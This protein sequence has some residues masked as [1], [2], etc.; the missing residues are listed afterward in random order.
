MTKRES[1]VDT[2]D[3]RTVLG[4]LTAAGLGLGLLGLGIPARAGG[5]G[6]A[7]KA[8]MTEK[9]FRMGVIGPATLSR[10]VSQLAVERATQANAREFARFELREAIA[11]TTVLKELKTPVPPMDAKARATL[12]K[13]ETA[14][15]GLDFDRAYVT[16]QYENHVFL[17]DLATTYL[18]NTTP[19]EPTFPE[20]QGRHLATLALNQFT[21]HVELTARILRE[22]GS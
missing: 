10:M 20:Q 14:A 17:R 21:E 4:R 2:T 3:R 5:A 6:M 7:M 1:A 15:P 11:V 13:I 12:T 19:S 18:A 8:G 22:L 9:D 16:A